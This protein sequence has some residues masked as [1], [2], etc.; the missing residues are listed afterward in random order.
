MAAVGVEQ[1]QIMWKVA[2]LPL[3]TLTLR[4]LRETT[5]RTIEKSKTS[6]DH[7][8]EIRMS[9]RM[10]GEEG[11]AGVVALETSVLN[12]RKACPTAIPSELYRK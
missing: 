10:E 2:L 6:T 3:G 8:P 11:N 5:G 7:G 1:R 4:P 9:E 12:K